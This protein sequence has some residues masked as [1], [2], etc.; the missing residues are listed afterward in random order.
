[1]SWTRNVSHCQLFKTSLSLKCS[2]CC[3][4]RYPA[5]VWM[6]TNSQGQGRGFLYLVDTRTRYLQT[7]SNLSNRPMMKKLGSAIAIL[8]RE[9]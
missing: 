4:L 1:M 3:D 2:K 5:V 8:T 6:L 7:V 9:L